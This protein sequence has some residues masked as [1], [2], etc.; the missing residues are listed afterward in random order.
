[1]AFAAKIPLP[2]AD[3]RGPVVNDLPPPFNIQ[4]VVV[5]KE[6]TLSWSWQPS[7]TMPAFM[8]FAYEIRRSDGKLG[9]VSELTFSDFD[10]AV[11]TYSY[12]VRVIGGSKENGRRVNHVSDYSEP[13]QA[14]VKSSCP[15]V[16]TIQLSVEPTQDSYSSVT[17][18]R[19]RLRGAAQVPEGCT[20]QK[21]TYKI[22][23]G[24]GT[25]RT[26]TLKIDAQGRFNELVDALT[27]EDEVPEGMATFTVTATARDEVGPI[28]SDAFTLSIELRNQFA[29]HQN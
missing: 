7:D 25:S 10:V 4:T 8:D 23:T 3:A 28:S 20:L 18:L 26:G 29:P 19:M 11:G 21:V 2:P 14:T 1:L 24:I 16:P 15:D 22:D 17:S 6:V 9:L 12:Q 5:N 27:P 13:A